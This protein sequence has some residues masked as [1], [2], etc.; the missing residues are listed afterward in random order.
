MFALPF[1]VVIISIHIEFILFLS[2][3]VC[4]FKE[5]SS[6]NHGKYKKQKKSILSLSLCFLEHTM[7]IT[8]LNTFGG[9]PV[10]PGHPFF[11]KVGV[12]TGSGVESTVWVQGKRGNKCHKTLH[13][14]QTSLKINVSIAKQNSNKEKLSQGTKI[15]TVG[16]LNSVCNIYK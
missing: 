4:N 3:Y 12:W 15:L 10:E 9:K 7:L 16:N 5:T 2:F 6:K 1:S 11:L 8:R 13:L 14:L